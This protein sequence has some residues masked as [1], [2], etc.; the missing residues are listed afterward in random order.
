MGATLLDG[1]RQEKES[2]RMKHN[3][4]LTRKPLRAQAGGEGDAKGDILLPA[5]ELAID[6][7]FR[8]KFG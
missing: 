7:S 8:K 1:P 6:M 4:L 5:L 2:H 3:R